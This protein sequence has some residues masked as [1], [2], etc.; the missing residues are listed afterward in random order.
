MTNTELK[1]IKDKYF[2]KLIFENFKLKGNILY[3][4]PLNDL[5]VGFCFEKSASVKGG[6]YVWSFVQPLYLPNDSIILTFGRRLENKLWE[7]KDANNFEVTMNK[8]LLSIKNEIENFVVKVDS[9]EK[10]YNYYSNKCENL[11]MTQGVVYSAVYLKNSES[12]L[13]LN[14]YI[15]ILKEQNLMIKWI[16]SLLIEA[17]YLKSIFSDRNEIDSFFNSKIDY[18][19]SNLNL[20]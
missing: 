10:F 18:T 9:A 13:L 7:L 17:E 2:D 5:V 11:R 16:N 1:K 12:E 8:L 15:K 19:K 4:F 6:I 20:E 14:N 3:K